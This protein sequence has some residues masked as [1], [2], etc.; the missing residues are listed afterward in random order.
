MRDHKLDCLHF[1]TLPSLAWAMALK[2]TKV[3]LD[4]ITDPD[5]FLM[6]ENSMPGG[7]ATISQRYASANNSLVE[8]HD[9]SVPNRYITYLD[10]NSLY[11]TA[12][13]EPLPVGNFRFLDDDEVQNFDLATVEADAE[14]GYIVE[15]DL[16]YPAHLHD[17]HNGYPMAAEHLTVTREMLSPHAER[18]LDPR[19]PWQPSKKLVQ[20]LLDKK[21]YVAHYRN[22]QLYTRHGLKVTKIHNTEFYTGTMVETVDRSL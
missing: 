2:H 9:T 11:A 1:I 20:N 16:E 22:L 3:E 10:A 21:N 4:L 19:R 18:L 7:I 17:L 15:C 14:V 5:A 12:Q 13:S 6:L 8:G